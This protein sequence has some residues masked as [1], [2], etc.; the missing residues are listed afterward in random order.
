MP[1][2][3]W[4]INGQKVSDEEVLSAS[5]RDGHYHR[6]PPAAWEALIRQTRRE[7]TWALSPSGASQCPRHQLLKA[8]EPYWLDPC[9]VWP[10][11][12]GTAWHTAF[13]NPGGDEHEERH[14]TVNLRVPVGKSVV[15]FPLRGTL[16]KY[17]PDTRRLT[18]YKTIG[19]FMAYDAATKKRSA[20]ALPLDYHIVQTNLY[21]L[22]LEMHRM[23]VEAIQIFYFKDDKDV[24]RQVV[25]VP[26]WDLEDTYQAAVDLA[27]PYAVARE[28]GL[29][30]P[31]SCK[32]RNSGLDRDLCASV[33]DEDWSGMPD[34]K[35]S[36]ADK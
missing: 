29:L 4:F 26:V 20:K 35:L 32:W 13:E 25:S 5:R 22:L 14:L 10:M 36:R 31:C 3:G 1:R 6:F 15:D 19:E 30:P 7:M 17:E 8:T 34:A 2:R 28:T 12:R 24:P 9:R 21:R 23:P 18:D 16:D 33:V 11:L 27:E